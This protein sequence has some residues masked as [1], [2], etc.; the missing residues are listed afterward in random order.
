LWITCDL[1]IFDREEVAL[2]GGIALI[3]D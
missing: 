1:G 2:G 3:V